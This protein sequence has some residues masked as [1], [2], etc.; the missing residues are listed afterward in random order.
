M[1]KSQVSLVL[2][3][4][5]VCGHSAPPRLSSIFLYNVKIISVKNHFAIPHFQLLYLNPFLSFDSYA[6]LDG[7][8]ILIW[9]NNA[10][11]LKHLLVDSS[12]H[13]T[14]ILSNTKLIIDIWNNSTV[15]CDAWCNGFGSIIRSSNANL[16]LVNWDFL[17]AV[18]GVDHL[19]NKK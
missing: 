7:I 14:N 17:I 11:M 8:P 9:N 10:K 2:H 16:W 19:Y 6:L 1:G 5:V 18:R 12:S 4:K 15:N 13:T 3:R